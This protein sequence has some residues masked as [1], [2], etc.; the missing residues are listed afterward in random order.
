MIHNKLVASA[1]LLACLSSAPLL[2]QSSVPAQT[3]PP[4]AP[5]ATQAPSPPPQYPVISVGTL[6]YLQYDAEL[7][8]R[9]AFNAFDV[10][11]AY[12]NINADLTP[13]VKFRLTPDLRRINDSSLGGSLVFRLKYGFVEF[14][15]L[16][17]RSWL[18]L[19]LHQTP[20]LDFEESINRYRVQGQM[21]SEREGV[22]PSSGDFGAGYLTRFPNDWGELNMGVYNGE[23]A[24]KGETDK[25]KSLQGRLTVRPFPKAALAK[26]FRISG[27]YNLGWYAKGQPRRNGIV[28]G[29]YE[30]PR[31]VATLQWLAA[32]ERPLAA[33]PRDFDRR[34]YSGFVEVRQGLEGWA[35]LLRVDHYDPDTAVGDNVTRR[36]IAGAAYWLRWSRVRIGLLVDDEDVRYGAAQRR[37]DE[38]RLLVQ[39]HVQF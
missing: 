30:H 39:T 23:G 21:F 24:S 14:D 17:P 10:T 22:I 32:T 15:N 2:A 36:V 9:Q 35:G 8:N 16:T 7:K 4:P 28:M 37:P 20:W 11:R 25:Y 12:I 18:R 31:L 29:S 3:Q 33:D 34:G 6:T 5:P 13:T 19:G 27:F 38:N 26:G 1:A